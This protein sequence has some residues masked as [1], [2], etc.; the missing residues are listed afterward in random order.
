MSDNFIREIVIIVGARGNRWQLIPALRGRGYAI[1]HVDVVWQPSNEPEDFSLCA[2]YIPAETPLQDIVERLKPYKVVAVFCGFEGGLEIA[3]ELADYYGVPGNSPTSSFCRNN[4]YSMNVPL[5][6]AGI[7]CVKQG[8]FNR[9]ENFYDWYDHSGFEKVVMKPLFG[10]LGSGVYFCTT[11]EEI[12]SVFE[13]HFMQK[14]FLGRLNDN[15]VIQEFLDGPTFWV[16]TVSRDGKHCTVVIIE[17][18][19]DTVEEYRYKYA[20]VMKRTDPRFAVLQDYMFKVLTA[21]GFNNGAAHSEVKITEEGPK[22][23]EINPRL[24]GGLV[25]SVIAEA[26]GCSQTEMSI[27]TMLD[28]GY[29]E[30][31]SKRIEEFQQKRG[32]F[33]YMVNEEEITMKNPPDY[34]IF[35]SL[36][37]FRTTAFF[38]K[39]GEVIP[40]STTLEDVPGYIMFLCDYDDDFELEFQEF[41]KLQREFFRKL[42]E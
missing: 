6:K 21:D 2:E 17:D 13:K 4:K 32:I 16:N 29:F 5:A 18:A 24:S 38:S 11:K 39:V 42:G 9:I 25:P 3:D 33:V 31:L 22:L 12:R 8:C 27:A 10:A 14:N 15:Y 40:R 34:S 23:V 37:S 28:A 30:I 36:P 35:A 1:A 41:R 20:T 7:P 19:G 26:C